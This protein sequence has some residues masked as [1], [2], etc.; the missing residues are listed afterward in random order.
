MLTKPKTQ[1]IF[2]HFSPRLF[3]NDLCQHSSL[4]SSLPSSLSPAPPLTQ[5]TINSVKSQIG[6][7]HNFF[8]AKLHANGD[9]PLV[10]DDDLPQKQRFPKP[11]LPPTGKI[12]SP[13]KRPLREQGPGKGH[14]R[15]K[16]KIQEEKEKEK[17]KEREKEREKEK[18][19]GNAKGK[20]GGV[21]MERLGS[22]NGEMG[23]GGGGE[24]GGMISPES[25][26]A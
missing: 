24:T 4:N 23:K 5:L 11:R 12:S 14:P 22:G 18:T 19:A 17:E 3:T 2:P 8:L 7:V 6:L 1:G 26:E 16:I 9:D 20:G 15:K 13:R 21:V 10:E 25:L